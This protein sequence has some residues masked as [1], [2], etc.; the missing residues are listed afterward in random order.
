MRHSVDLL[1]S[2]YRF[3][4]VGRNSGFEN[5]QIHMICY[6]KDFEITTVKTDYESNGMNIYDWR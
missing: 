6:G 4:R 1:E 2:D 3:L 5:K